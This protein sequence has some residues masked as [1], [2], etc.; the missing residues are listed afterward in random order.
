MV[1]VFGTRKRHRED[2]MRRRMGVRVRGLR[3]TGMDA[4]GGRGFE[5]LCRV[6]VA[7]HGD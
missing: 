7:G 1:G 3:N 2:R 4:E 6:L 5:E